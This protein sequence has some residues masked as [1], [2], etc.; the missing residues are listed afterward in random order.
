M[1]GLSLEIRRKSFAS[2]AQCVVEDCRLRVAEGEFVALL[3]PSGCGKTTLLN[4]ICGLDR[5]YDG[6]VVF[7]G[8]DID[9]IALGYVFQEPRLLPWA[10]VL[11]NVQLVLPEADTQVAHALLEQVELAD[12]ADLYPVQLSGGMRRRAALARAFAV[13]PQLLLL[14]EPFVSLDVPTAQRLR[15]Q[16]LELWRQSSPSVL[17]VTHDLREALVLADRVLFTSQRPARVIKELPVT[18]PRPRD[19]DGKA[20]AELH[21][22]LLASHPGLLSGDSAARQ[23]SADTEVVYG[24][25]S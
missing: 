19:P 1:T 21:T 25:A 18:L 13:R 7:A 6:S 22:E 12:S 20:I 15:W 10:T 11:E 17:F 2:A 9:E 16:L 4:L 14:D 8:R 24:G 3:G 23:G 5:D